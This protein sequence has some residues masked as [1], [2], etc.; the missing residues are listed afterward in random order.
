MSRIVEYLRF[1][2]DVN[3]QLPLT[4]SEETEYLRTLKNL[5]SDKSQ[6]VIFSHLYENLSILD[7]KSSSLLTFNA[8][9]VAVFAIFAS[10]HTGLFIR[11]FS[12]AG[13]SLSLL[14]SS[15]LMNV[16]W[17]HWSTSDHLLD[18]RTHEITLLSVRR[19]RTIEYRKAWNLSK[20]SLL[21]VFLIIFVNLFSSPGVAH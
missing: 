12:T 10:S 9:I 7:S 14:S 3:A 11:L 15:I 21:A 5:L 20:A 8:I 6:E 13:I 2:R 4:E 1:K 18:A 17:V 19:D 16:V